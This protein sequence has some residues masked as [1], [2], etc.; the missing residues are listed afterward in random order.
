MVAMG[1]FFGDSSHGVGGAQDRGSDGHLSAWDRR[2]YGG[3]TTGPTGVKRGGTAE[4]TVSDRTVVGR[5]CCAPRERWE[6]RGTC[7]HSLWDAR[8]SGL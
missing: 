7:H 1:V 3:A 8:R 4:E 2:A 6:A 5:P